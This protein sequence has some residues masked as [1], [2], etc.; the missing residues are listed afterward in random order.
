MTLLV[1]FICCGCHYRVE[2]NAAFMYIEKLYPGSMVTRLSGCSKS[3]FVVTMP[4]K[5]RVLK[6]VVKNRSIIMLDNWSIRHYD[7]NIKGQSQ[8]PIKNQQ[9]NI[10]RQQS[11]KLKPEKLDRAKWLLDCM[12]QSDRENCVNALNDLLALE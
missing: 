5:T 3:L 8:L 2:N 11:E 4:N 9:T 10:I 7:S 1:I 12:K 6:L